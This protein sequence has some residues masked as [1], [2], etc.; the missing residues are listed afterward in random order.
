MIIRL[1]I[2]FEKRE[3]DMSET[4]NTEIRNNRAE[5]K[6]SVNKMRNTFNEMNSRMVEAEE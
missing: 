3:E 2:G 4:L 6:G 1:L 5:I